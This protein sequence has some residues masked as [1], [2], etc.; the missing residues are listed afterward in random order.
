MND[1]PRI[2]F[3]GC[4]RGLDSTALLASMGGMS[5]ASEDRPQQSSLP[6]DG[7]NRASELL[8]VSE[9]AGVVFNDETG[10]GVGVRLR[11]RLSSG[12]GMALP[13][14]PGALQ[15][16]D[17][18]CSQQSTLHLLPIDREDGASELLGAA[19]QGCDRMER[20]TKWQLELSS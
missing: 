7:A 14:D 9:V 2:T 19:G 5:K 12:A 20:P 18:V 8:G 16:L 4:L 15:A 6:G 17:A 1:G 11:D 3:E 13:R 10:G